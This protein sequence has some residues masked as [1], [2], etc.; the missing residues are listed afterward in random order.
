MTGPPRA[1]PVRNRRND[2]LPDSASNGSRALSAP[3]CVNRNASPW[4]VFVPERV[5]TLIEPPEAPPDSAE[6]PLL[7]TTISGE[8]SVRLEP[9]H[10]SLL[11]RPSI[12]R[13][14]VRDLSPP[15][16]KPLPRRAV[17]ALARLPIGERKN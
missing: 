5:T 12:E 14:L 8:S 7:T 13:L 3:S 4:T 17:E 11:S 2:G 1:K 16:L 10:S 15:N 6:R 9:V